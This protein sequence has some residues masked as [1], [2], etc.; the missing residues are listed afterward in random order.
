MNVLIFENT[1]C[2]RF[3]PEIPARALRDAYPLAYLIY[4]IS[5]FQVD[6]SLDIDFFNISSQA[7][8]WKDNIVTSSYSNLQLHFYYRR[9]ISQSELTTQAIETA[10]EK[11]HKFNWL[12]RVVSPRPFSRCFETAAERKAIRKVESG[13]WTIFRVGLGRHHIFFG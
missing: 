9:E 12:R 1:Y 11:L 8:K 6:T 4:S 13:K 5:F 3:F 2:Y 10:S 7:Q